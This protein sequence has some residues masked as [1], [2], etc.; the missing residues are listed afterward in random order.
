M[1]QNS[2]ICCFLALLLSHAIT[3]QKIPKG[4]AS[5]KSAIPSI[6]IDLRYGT[7]E[8]FTGRI[9]DGYQKPKAVLTQSTLTALRNAQLKFESYGVGIKLFDGYRPQ[10]AVNDFIAWSNDIN[11]TLQ[12][13]T[14]YPNINKVE[15]FDRGY[16]ARRSGHSRGSTVDITL[17]YTTGKNKG[18]EVDMG[19][20]WD[21]F[22]TRSWIESKEIS[23]Q[24]QS[25]RELLQMVMKAAGF[26]PYS[27]E[28]WHFTLVKEPFPETYFDF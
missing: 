26:R 25:N 7:T 8:N 27:K 23:L 9:V 22:G 28:W 17:V 13:A 18:K 3:G 19:G 21:F 1:R 24:Q 12:K 11:D 14:Y 5:V 4:F 16:I 20:T 6:I 10:K 2:F 15:L